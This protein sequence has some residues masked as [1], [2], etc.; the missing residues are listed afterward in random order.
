[1]S[2]SQ[3]NAEA[4]GPSELITSAFVLAQREQAAEAQKWVGVYTRLV[5]LSELTKI[6]E[7][8]SDFRTDLLLR[9]MEA[10]L[11]T[12][13]AAPDDDQ[14]H[15]ADDLQHTLTRYWVRS[16]YDLL[17]IIRGKGKASENPRIQEMYDAFRL[18]RVPMAKLQIAQDKKL[19]RVPIKLVSVGASGA[20][21]SADYV[22]GNYH[23][24]TLVDTR[25]GSIGWA[26]IDGK[27]R[28]ETMLVRRTLSDRLLNL[29]DG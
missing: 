6:L 9:A 4:L 22:K 19:S 23:P 11:A 8:Q 18:I 10:R 13:L 24:P 28:Q 12:R 20:D 14:I 5:G 25:T 29:F 15:Y 1:M 17:C 7:F 16:V 26:V 21:V 2:T 27:S 3:P